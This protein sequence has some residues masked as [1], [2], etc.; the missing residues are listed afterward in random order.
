MDLNIRLCIV[1]S[2]WRK[3]E[4]YRFCCSGSGPAGIVQY[5]ATIKI[6]YPA[7]RP[8]PLTYVWGPNKAERDG[9]VPGR[10]SVPFR[11]RPPN[12]WR[13]RQ[14]ID[15]ECCFIWLWAK[16]F[17]FQSDDLHS[18]ASFCCASQREAACICWNRNQH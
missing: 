9:P 10:R 2:T 1:V 11:R 15:N 3:V 18:L 16:G 12:W 8:I 5:S 14:L 13:P 4:H 17:G 6:R 7:S